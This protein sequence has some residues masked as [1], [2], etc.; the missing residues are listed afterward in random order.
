MPKIKPVK[1]VQ[2]SNEDALRRKFLVRTTALLSTIGASVT[3]W[4]FISSMLPD[5]RA[6]AAGVNILVDVSNIPPGF[7]KT[8]EWRKKPVWVMHRTK[9]MITHLND[10]KLLE[11]LR[12]P[13]SE[14]QSQQ[15]EYAINN[16]R[17]IHSEYFVA[18]GIC[19][20]LGCSPSL[21]PNI[22]TT[23]FSKNWHGGYYCPCHGSLFD[24]AGRVYKNVPAPTNLVI[25]PYRFLTQTEIE[26]GE[27]Q[28]Q[29]PKISN[30]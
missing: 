15:P 22:G 10:Q 14:A 20:H 12:D 8:V 25:P 19:T 28:F 24:L 1:N 18:I 7:Q 3:S 23:P 21:F 2:L 26:I 16:T 5:A 29:L 11:Q 6:E 13:L 30:T 9:E 27:D 17:S 4:P